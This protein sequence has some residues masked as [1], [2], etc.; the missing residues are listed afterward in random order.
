M[1]SKKPGQDEQDQEI[2][3]QEKQLQPH[4]RPLGVARSRDAVDK[5]RG[6]SAG[7]QSAAWARAARA[8][9]GHRRAIPA[10]RQVDR[11]V[12]AT[13]SPG[14]GLAVRS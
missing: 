4:L 5:G 13:E 8:R 7:R 10:G 1:A 11:G 12:R 3:E 14:S 9:G 2:Q 6:S